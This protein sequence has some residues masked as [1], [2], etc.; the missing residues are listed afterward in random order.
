[1]SR[2]GDYLL[3]SAADD[4]VEA[5]TSREHSSIGTVKPNERVESELPGQGGTKPGSSF[6]LLGDHSAHFGKGAGASS[7]TFP[8]IPNESA[9]GASMTQRPNPKRPTPD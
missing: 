2:V 7:V 6:Y 9:Y 5:E 1:M 3:G 4:G 8:E